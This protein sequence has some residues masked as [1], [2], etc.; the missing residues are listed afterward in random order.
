MNIVIKDFVATHPNE[1]S[2]KKA[3]YVYVIEK[4]YNGYWKVEINHRIGYVPA[5]HLKL[6]NE[7]H[8]NRM[9]DTNSSFD[10]SDEEIMPNIN[11]STQRN[12]FRSSHE[13]SNFPQPHYPSN[14]SN[15][16]LPTNNHS[17]QPSTLPNQTSIEKYIVV[18]DY[19]SPDNETISLRKDQIVQ[20]LDSQSS[21]EWWF[22]QLSDLSEGW[23]PSSFLK[24][25]SSL[26][27]I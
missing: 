7:P 2:I 5:N 6:P 24:V 3:E 9:E 1:I 22:I 8:K 13:S 15:F 19:L 27:M 10:E 16:Y 18:E 14:P 20:V 26:I 12:E 23:A 17:L 21:S 11:K 25:S 4:N